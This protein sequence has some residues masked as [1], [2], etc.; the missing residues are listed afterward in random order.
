MLKKIIKKKLIPLALFMGMLVVLTSCSGS[1]SIQGTWMVQDGAGNNSKIVISSKTIKVEGKTY[2]YKQ[3]AVGV[4]NGIHYYGIEED[5]DSYSIIFPKKNSE[6]ALLVLLDNDDD[7]LKGKL[8]YAMNKKEQ[9]DYKEY[10][11]KYFS[12]H[13]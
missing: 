5:G 8:I 3:N 4:E 11:K 1:K 7:Y 13:S 9:P 12:Q 6:A 2:K 10:V